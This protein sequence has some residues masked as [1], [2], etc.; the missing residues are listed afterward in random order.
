[1][2]PASTTLPG[3]DGRRSGADRV[4]RGGGSPGRSDPPG[5]RRAPDRGR[6]SARS[7]RG[8]LPRAPLRARGGG[9]AGP[10]G[11]R[12]AR[13]S[14]SPA[15]VPLRG[16]RLLGRPRRLL[17]SA[18]QPSERGP[19]PPARH[20]DHSVPRAHRG[21]APARSGDGG[22]RAART[23]HHR[24]PHRGRAG[25]ARSLQPR[26]PLDHREL[27]GT[28]QP[29]PRA[30]GPARARAL[31]AGGQPPVPDPDARQPE[32]R[33]LAS[34]GL[35]QGGGGHRPPARAQPGFRGGAAGPRRGLEQHGAARARGGR[36]GAV[37][38]RLPQRGGS[39][40][41]AQPAPPRPPEARAAQ[42]ISM[43]VRGGQNLYGFSVGILMLDTQFPRIPGDMG[44]ATTF[45]FPV[46]YHRVTGASPDRV[47]RQGQR[48]LLP[49]FIE[50]ARFLEREGVRAVTTNCGFLAMYQTDMAAAVSI[51]VFT[52]SLM[53][54]PLVYRMLPPG[55]VVGIMTVDAPSLRP[56]HF[57]GAG[58]TRDIPTVVAG[59]ETEKEFTR[60]MLDNQMEMDVEIARQEH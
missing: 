57:A 13:T 52:S 46:R 3:V 27:P 8:R 1:G 10:A 39:R 29:R 41:G 22:D 25:A 31:R 58:I 30:A 4:R 26:R 53:L 2:P 18:Q 16:T 24:R 51:P 20:P 47:V 40:A 9:R 56:D 42:L 59:L 35:G 54:V 17:R 15:R 34:R 33:L 5:P 23:L 37:P 32:G 43:R 28:G 14:P 50:G 45:D 55:K 11:R 12:R 7:R 60:V 21:R 44:N 6:R 38:R 19:E 36:L 48:E 49:S